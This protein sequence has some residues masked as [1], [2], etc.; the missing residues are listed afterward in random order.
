M[1]SSTT[2]DEYVYKKNLSL[3][4]RSKSFMTTSTTPKE[5]KKDLSILPEWFKSLMTYSATPKV[6]CSRKICGFF[7]SDSRAW[8][9][10]STT[11]G[12]LYSRKNCGFFLRDSQASLP[13]QLIPK[14]CVQEIFLGSSWVI[15]E[16]QYFFNYSK[17]RIVL[18]NLFYGDIISCFL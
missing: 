11:L 17:R 5:S 12:E 15:Q 10:F 9:T 13:F 6:L 1:T 2:S 8:M 18:K 7:M 16:L 14:N 4:A 3:L